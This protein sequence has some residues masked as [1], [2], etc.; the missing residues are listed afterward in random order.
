MLGRSSAPRR[1]GAAVSGVILIAS[2]A[3]LVM[4]AAPLDAD[5]QV[6]APAADAPTDAPTAVPRTATSPEDVRRALDALRE[7]P[8]QW[9]LPRARQRD[10]RVPGLNFGLPLLT[11]LLIA[12]G[13]GAALCL[14]FLIASAARDRRRPAVVDPAT[15]I[16]LAS[17]VRLTGA[18]LE[19]A[20]AAAREGRFGEAIHLLLLGTIDE[21]RASLR[22]DAHP[23]LTSRE[24]LGRAPLPG[25]AEAPLGGI[26]REVEWSHFGERG[27]TE[28][29]Y[30]R[31][32]DWHAELRRACEGAATV[33]RAAL[34]NPQR[35]PQRGAR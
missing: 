21:I 7:A 26:I 24:I 1:S 10:V 18:P 6:D 14:A 25:G 19:R 28:A 35:N 9:E 15:E 34:R 2:V 20:E 13:I 27:A 12:L 22:Y 31:C 29:E 11:L 23:S 16:P 32:V 5:A 4:P 33:E 8:I 30:R 3:M 17:P